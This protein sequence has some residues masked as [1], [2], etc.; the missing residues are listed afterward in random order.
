MIFW[1]SRPH[2]IWPIVCKYYKSTTINSSSWLIALP[3]LNRL[4]R[5]P[6]L[7]SSFGIFYQ[8]VIALTLGS[9]LLILLWVF[10]FFFFFSME[11]LFYSHLNY[12][13]KKSY[14]EDYKC[15]LG[16]FLNKI[17]FNENNLKKKTFRDTLI[18]I[19]FCDKFDF[20]F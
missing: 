16:F 7:S 12:S 13:F 4:I 8:P 20:L 17:L 18:K 10:C 3:A 1:T 2:N 15:N 9:L 14:L 5:I 19:T 6:R 11:Q